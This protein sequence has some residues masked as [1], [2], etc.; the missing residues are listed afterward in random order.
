MGFA[1]RLPLGR[2]PGR[3]G[4]GDAQPVQGGLDDHGVGARADGHGDPRPSAQVDEGACAGHGLAFGLDQLGHPGG[5]GPLGLG[6]GHPLP[7]MTVPPVAH[8]VVDAQ[9]HGLAGLLLGE[10]Q[11][12]RGEDLHLGPAPE[13]LG[14]D[15][16]AV[17]VEHHR[18]HRPAR[19]GVGRWEAGRA[20]GG[21]RRDRQPSFRT[22]STMASPASVGLRATVTPAAA[23]ASILA[24]AVPLEPEMMAPAWPILRPGGAVTPAT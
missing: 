5:D 13:R 10:M 1:Q 3:H 22:T 2:V 19:E 23:S 16:Q 15:Q 12:E 18:G 21:V 8:G 7:R 4:L 24:W 11:A 17:E 9:A 20:A 6:R 14:V